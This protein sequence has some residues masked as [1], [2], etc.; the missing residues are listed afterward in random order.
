M[1]AKF[2]DLPTI[3][4]SHKSIDNKTLY[5]TADI[6][7]ILICKEGDPS[8][9]ES[10]EQPEVAKKKKD[11]MKV[12][13]KFIFPHGVCPPLKNCRKR[14]FRKT[15]KKKFVEAP[16]IEKEVKRLLRHDNEAVDVKWDLVTEEELNASKTG[17]I[18]KTGGA[19]V[20]ETKDLFGELSD[21]D[22]DDRPNANIDIDS[23]GDSNMFGF[24]GGP[25]PAKSQTPL[26]TQFSKEMF[27]PQPSS[28]MP[29]PGPSTS[30][31]PPQP[32]TDAVARKVE[33][34]RSDI[35]ELKTRK[36]ELESNLQNCEFEVLQRTFQQSLQEVLNELQ[37]KE[38][39]ADAFSMFS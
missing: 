32:Q 2:M 25:S 7:Q 15:L 29:A 31:Q 33:Q 17:G 20:T 3:I 1:S 37:Q 36:R 13:K 21:S 9:D 24:E 23:E 18:D 34:L 30:E 16:E 22:D 27:P 12:D 8:E 28:E 6:C 39:E 5:K 11:S 38:M 26:V 19:S 10:T 14:R 4:E 35:A